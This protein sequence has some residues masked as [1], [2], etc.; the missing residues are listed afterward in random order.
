[1]TD[2]VGGEERY[3]AMLR[4]GAD[5]LSPDEIAMFDNVVATGDVNACYFAIQALNRRFTEAVGD[6]KELL[7][8]RGSRDTMDVFRSQAEVIEA[9]KDPKYDTDPAYRNDVFEKLGRSNINYWWPPLLKT[10]DAKTFTL[11]NHLYDLWWEVHRV[12]QREGWKIEWTFRYDGSDCCHRS[13]RHYWSAHS[14]YL[15]M[16]NRVRLSIGRGEKRKAEDGA[17]LC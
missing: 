8:G 6:E 16:S 10:A 1:M 9:M 11:K 3:D 12:T 4:W 13:L 14:R 7:T 15:V 17:G 5:N 2:S